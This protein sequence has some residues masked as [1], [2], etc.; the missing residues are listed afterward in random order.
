MRD[1][2][3]AS[4]ACLIDALRRDP[5]LRDEDLAD[6]VELMRNVLRWLRRAVKEDRK[7]LGPVLS[8][9]LDAMFLSSLENC[10]FLEE[11][12]SR[13]CLVEYRGLEV[14]CAAVHRGDVEPSL[15][16]LEAA[17]RLT[18]AKAMVDFVDRFRHVGELFSHDIL[19]QSRLNPC[20]DSFVRLVMI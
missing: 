19:R 20:A 9:Y 5:D 18:W 2:Y 15:G 13:Q 7:H 10:W 8:P 16:L 12:E 11:F 4:S 17:K 6:E 14:Y 3:D 1:Y